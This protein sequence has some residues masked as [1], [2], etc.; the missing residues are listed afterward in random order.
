MNKMFITKCPN[1]GNE[2][3]I[4]LIDGYVCPDCN[5]LLQIPY[6]RCDKC[7]GT[8]LEIMYT[9]ESIVHHCYDGCGH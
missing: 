3:N 2:L 6:E 8:V 4:E 5:T 1:C 9:D 7:G